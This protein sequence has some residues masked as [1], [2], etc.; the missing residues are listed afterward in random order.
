MSAPAKHWMRFYQGRSIPT[1]KEH[2]ADQV[3]AALQ[4]EIALPQHLR[5]IRKQ[6]RK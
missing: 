3:T 1:E 2:N 5:S 6:V 4:L